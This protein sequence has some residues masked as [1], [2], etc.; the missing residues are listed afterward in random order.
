MGWIC[1][2]EVEQGTWP[3]I[4]KVCRVRY[5]SIADDIAIVQSRMFAFMFDINP[6]MLTLV[7]LSVIAVTVMLLILSFRSAIRRVGTM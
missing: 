5:Y 1:L 4:T 2:H 7:I 3:I 6:A